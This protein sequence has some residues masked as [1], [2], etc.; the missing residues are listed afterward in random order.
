V[1]RND[2]RQGISIVC[3]YNNPAVRRECLD[4]SIEAYAGDVDVDYVPVDNTEHA[5]R[6]AGAALNHGARQARHQVVAFVHQDVYLHSID[7]LVHVAE[8]FDHG[9]WGL[10]GANGVTRT[11]ENVGHVRDRVQVL[12]RPAPTPV[13]VDS[14]DEVLFMASRDLLLRYPL[15]EDSDLAWHAYCVEYAARLRLLGVRVGAVDMAITHNSVSINLDN[16]D[17][18]HE[19]V[20][21]MYPQLQPIRTTCGVIGPAESPWRQSSLVRHHGW[22]VRWLRHSLLAAKVRRRLDVPVVLSDIRY[23]VDLVPFGRGD[24]LHL[25]NLDRVSDFPSYASEPLL[26]TRFDRPIM[27]RAVSTLAD[28]AEALDHLPDRSRILIMGFGLS[29]LDEI[30]KL[31]RQERDWI[32]GIHPDTLWL[33][34]GVPVDELPPEWSQRQAVPLGSRPTSPVTRSA[35]ASA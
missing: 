16:L 31:T 4:R 5:F 19:R 14:L 34:G 21:T 18:A 17:V 3:V 27:M 23:E 22:R 20:G 29:D 28:I 32:F 25:F 8:S 1:S 13:E 11:G 2:R 26:F 30:S 6:S 9:V 33:L 12:G 10:L 35:I 7:R 24:A 15:T